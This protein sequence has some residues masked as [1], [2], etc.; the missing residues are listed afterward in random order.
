MAMVVSPLTTAVMNS[1]PDRRSGAASGVN[2]A[3]SRLTGVLAIAVFGAAASLV[4]DWR[5][6]GGRFGVLP[7]IGDP[8]R[9]AVESAFLAAYSTAMALAA[10]WCFIAALAARLSLPPKPAAT[11][12]A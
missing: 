8:S 10:L 7:P 5:V 4:F 3:A 6:P 9:P 12:P 1:V 2:N 11:G